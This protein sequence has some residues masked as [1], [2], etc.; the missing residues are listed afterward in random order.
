MQAQSV[1]RGVLRLKGPG[2]NNQKTHQKGGVTDGPQHMSGVTTLC[3]NGGWVGVEEK[4]HGVMVED[5]WGRNRVNAANQY[6]VKTNLDGSPPQDEI[7]HDRFG[8]F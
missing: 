1:F 3:V 8:Q 5:G 2:K 6:A 4:D 7:A